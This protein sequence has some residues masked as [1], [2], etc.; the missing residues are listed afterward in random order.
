[1]IRSAQAALAICGND[2]KLWRRRPGQI[3]S[4]IILAAAYGAA[5]IA[6][7]Q[8]V[9]REPAAIVNLDR[10]PVGARLV[11]AML[12]SDVLDY[13]VTTQ[14]QAAH[15]YRDLQ[16]AAVITIPRNT[17]WRVRRHQQVQVATEAN[18][19]N[20]DLEGDLARAVPVGIVAY[21]GT[22]GRASPVRVMISTQQMLH[23]SIQ[24]WQYSALPIII[25]VTTVAG[26]M[27]GGMNVANEYQRR[28]I[29]PIL[30][31]PVDH[32]TV[33]L[34]KL[35]AGF[36]STFGIAALALA[37]S[38]ALGMARPEGGIQYWAA[39][40]AILALTAAFGAGLGL[41][42]GVFSQR[43]LAVSI[44]ATIIAVQ[45][46]AGAGGIGNVFFEP[47][48]LQ[49]VAA[50]DPLTYGIHALQQSTFYASTLGFARDAAVMAAAA[51]ATVLAGS[52]AMRRR[53]IVQ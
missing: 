23:R 35:L 2:L 32:L 15:M 53:L 27:S 19:L 4:A 9:G 17:T 43:K 28:T 21:Y 12:G 34:G 8:A 24:L 14:A 10:G 45:L 16:V 40:L 51:A 33:I 50:Y 46:F 31:A 39:A 37:G 47:Q 25:L 20:L 18:N 29:K 6:S 48:T 1:M 41:A 44:F 30:L 13:T 26:I 22:L 11:Q 38:A 49:Q 52:I 7:S 42:V 36:L 3:I 5:V